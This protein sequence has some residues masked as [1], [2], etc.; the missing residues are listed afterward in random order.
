MKILK[1]AS[2]RFKLILGFVAISILLFT[3]GV[4]SAITLKVIAQSGKT[5]YSNHLQSI[6][7][8]HIIKE[9][10]LNIRINLD[11]IVDNR[12]DEVTKLNI[13]EIER[14]QED[15]VTYIQFYDSV[16]KLPEEQQLWEEFNSAMEDYREQ[17]QKVLDFALSGNY[18]DAEGEMSDV[19]VIRTAMFE[20]LDELI[21]I[22]I[23]EAD[24]TSNINAI[25]ADRSII[26][27]NCITFFGFIIA[28][29]L[30]LII[31]N[32]IKKALTY[33]VSYAEAIGNGDLTYNLKV[34][35]GNDEF[36]HLFDALNKSKDNL[37]DLVNQIMIQSNEV[38]ASSEELSATMEELTNDFNVIN[39]NTQTIVTDVMD[40]NAVTEELSATVEQ[41]ETG[42][43]QLS[44]IA[45]DGNDKSF[46]IM[47]RAD[48]IRNQ[49]LDSKK[50]ADDMYEEKHL[51]VVNAIEKGKI[52][53]QIFAIADSISKIAKQTNLLSLNASIESARAGEHGKGFAVVAEQIRVLAEQSSNYVKDIGK[54][55]IDVQE[56]FNDLENSSN[57]MLDFIDKRVRSDYDLLVN[58]GEHYDKD[59]LFVNSF[60]KDT[61]SMAEEMNATTKEI[62]S[63]IQNIANNMQSTTYS[64]EEILKSMNKTKQAVEQVSDMAIKQSEIA[65]NLCDIIQKFKI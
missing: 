45:R 36:G 6:N 50:I 21:Q 26:T 49:G 7:S 31:S 39:Q 18:D 63:I 30:G 41:A 5:M 3:V 24:D 15:D 43:N 64:S 33:G 40:I 65:E 25:I 13:S 52:V 48:I 14:L 20:K 27:I 17:R 47:K 59:A 46:D 22:S 44:V 62:S 35:Y 61:A 32:Y 34:K 37:K 10:L 55:V 1:K 53:G 51:R 56:A 16:D 54:V 28:I 60:S 58:T 38:S 29:G 9:D 57:Q 42:T 2:V 11:E 4:L 19:T 8:L 12:D 23:T